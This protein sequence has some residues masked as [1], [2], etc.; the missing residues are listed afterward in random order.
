MAENRLFLPQAA[1]DAWMADGR[2]RL[3][4]EELK[5]E[6]QGY[7][8]HLTSALLFKAEVT[9][10]PDAYDLVGKAKSLEAVSALSGEHCADS[11]ILGDN[12]YEVE[13]GFLAEPLAKFTPPDDGS[14]PDPLTRLFMEL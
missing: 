6:P 5:L 12:A 9:G 11:V 14:Q 4:G 10:S 13:E 3:M 1:V 2:A 7:T 8:L